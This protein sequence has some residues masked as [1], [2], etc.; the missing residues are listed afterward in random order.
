MQ[1]VLSRNPK[2]MVDA[3]G[4]NN[5][6]VLPLEKLMQNAVLPALPSLHGETV[7]ATP[8]PSVRAVAPEREAFDP[9]RVAREP[10]QCRT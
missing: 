8:A 4:S 9:M 10:R 2:V 1:D 7:T 3:G 5:M 6:M